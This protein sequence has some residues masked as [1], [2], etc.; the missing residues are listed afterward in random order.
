MSPC[1]DILRRTMACVL[2]GTL[3]GLAPLWAHAQSCPPGYY[4]ASDGNCY[5]APPPS[6]PPPI[7]DAAPPVATP[8]VVM[9]GLMIG[10][11]LLAGAVIFGDHGER[12]APEAYRPPPRRG[13]PER[14]GERGHR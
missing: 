10:L 4:Y 1:S 9:D 13:P 14:R 2:I 5:P 7:Y 3:A 8:P 12:R 11:G 6:Y